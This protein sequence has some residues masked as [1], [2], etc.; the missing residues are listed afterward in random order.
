MK[1]KLALVLSGGGS[2]G[3]LQVGALR[4]VFE[5]GLKPD[6]LVGT[7]IGAC[8]AAFL[9]I[10]GFDQES[11]D[12]LELVWRDAGSANLLPNNFLWMTVRTI[13]NRRTPNYTGQ[14][15]NFLVAHGLD[16]KLTFQDL[17]SCRLYLVAADI[18]QG[19]MVLFGQEPLQ[20]ILE[21]VI[22]SAAIPPWITPLVN[23]DQLLMDGGVISNLP[24][25]PA[26]RAGAE[27]IIALDLESPMNQAESQGIGPFMAK[28]MGTVHRR[29]NELEL[30]FAHE[31][32]IP[33]CHIHLCDAQIPIWDFS[34]S[35]EMFAVGYQRAKEPLEQWLRTQRP[36]SWSERLSQ[37]FE[38][39]KKKTR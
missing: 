20:S 31:R 17:N 21:G 4:A 3:A 12:R 15:R 36:L 18:N 1:R 10:Q 14:L 25:L 6:I 33:V 8:N 7:S 2:R 23:G 39:I 16:P 5:T 32:N 24:I 34:H 22:A 38:I 11:L 27:E 9:A 13:F 26:I 28:V 30:A 29:Q 35:E 19:K 37:K